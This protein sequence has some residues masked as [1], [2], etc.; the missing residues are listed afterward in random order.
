[1][2]DIELVSLQYLQYSP[3]SIREYIT[4]GIDAKYFE[5]PV[6]N[7]VYRTITDYFQSF[8]K[9]IPKQ[10]L[11]LNLT[12]LK[13]DPVVFDTYVNPNFEELMDLDI[14][15]IIQELKN[16]RKKT[17]M[18]NGIKAALMNLNSDDTSRA[19]FDLKDVVKSLSTVETKSNLTVDFKSEMDSIIST[20]KVPKN[21][22]AHTTGYF[23]IDQATGGFQ[24][25]W[26]VLLAALPK[27]GKTRSL[28]NMACGMVKHKVNVLVFTLEVPK[29]Q[30]LNLCIS[31]F[32]NLSFTD[33][34]DR[35]LSAG[36]WFM[37]DRIKK[38]MDSGEW[39]NLTIVDSLGSCTP[40]YIDAQIDDL[41]LKTGI[42]YDVIVVDHGTMMRATYPT[43]KD[44]IDQGAIA[45]DLRAIARKRRVTVL[46]AVQRK[47]AEKKSGR[48]GASSGD[49]KEAEAGGES[50]GRSFIWFQ[51]ADIVMIIQ[52]EQ[53][54]DADGGVSTLRYKVISRYGP[55]SSF[56]LIKDFG[57]T[58]LLSVKGN[59]KLKGM[60]EDNSLG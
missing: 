41:Q 22:I 18:S 51:T 21:E 13:L 60:W 55:S 33:V 2:L 35:K 40:E 58:Q 39:G 36:D 49:Q 43:G 16:K 15:W 37:I 19:E 56:E 4:F 8:Q 5:N 53:P 6:A 9:M 38:Q 10:A 1:M 46:A 30:Y 48:R 54:D 42:S 50:I 26:L 27:L 11:T 57:K 20:L 52:N 23:E 25:G 24:P 29:E 47:V 12:Q 17:L 34:R 7:I 32:C 44:N 14:N 31:C 45:E 3:D 28:I 59:T